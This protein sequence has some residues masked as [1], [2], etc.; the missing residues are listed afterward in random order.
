[1]ASRIT[2]S[3]LQEISD[4]FNEFSDNKSYLDKD[5]LKVA[6][7]ALLGFRPSKFDVQQMLALAT[8]RD[9]QCPGMSRDMFVESMG[10]R[11]ALVDPAEE[12]RQI[13]KAFD[14]GCRGFIT[15][16]DLRQVLSEVFSESEMLPVKVAEMFSEAD[17]DGSGRVGTRSYWIPTIRE[18]DD[19][20][21]SY[22]AGTAKGTPPQASLLN[23][24][25]RTVS[26]PE[27]KKHGAL[28]GEEVDEAST[29]LC[30]AFFPLSSSCSPS[31]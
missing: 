26:Q 29:L 31:A 15:R 19:Q 24:A 20:P 17:W 28:V 1:M 23:R 11:L 13:F 7:T 14:R 12:L 16:D 10:R 8:A 18:H 3:K 5:D 25:Q 22:G 30:S 21:A 27:T 2:E 6:V 4:C 9:P